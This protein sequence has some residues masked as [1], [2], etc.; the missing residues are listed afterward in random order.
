MADRWKGY[1]LIV[2]DPLYRALG[3]RDEN[4][5][6]DMAKV[7]NRVDAAAAASGAAWLICHHSSKG[8]QTLKSVT[9]VG[10]GAGS[11]S[12]A[13]DCHLILRP[14]AVPGV[15]VVEAAVRSF[16][17]LPAFC[18]SFNWPLWQRA[19]E[20]LDPSD[21]AGRPPSAGA[22]VVAARRDL[23]DDANAVEAFLQQTEQ[24]ANLSRVVAGVQLSGRTITEKRT[25]AA[26]E[27][28]VIE[29]R[30]GTM[31][32]PLGANK[33]NVPA[34]STPEKIAQ[35]AQNKPQQTSDGL[36]PVVAGCSGAEQEEQTAPALLEGGADCSVRSRNVDRKRTRRKSNSTRPREQPDLDSES[37]FEPWPSGTEVLEIAQP[38][39]KKSARKPRK[40]APKKA[41]PRAWLVTNKGPRIPIE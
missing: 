15:A 21:L 11:I 4:A 33:R 22:K 37:A 14:H 5:N 2:L 20:D 29:K 26:L 17:P 16:P 38:A 1:S 36:L 41:K 30:A 24:P 10:S 13:S 28:L 9:D 12:R 6:S 23:E 31:F 18:A 7:F 3:E 8:G 35:A 32:L 39:P 27:R 19:S 25:R 40:A 34:Y